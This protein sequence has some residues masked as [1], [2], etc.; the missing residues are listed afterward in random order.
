MPESSTSHPP[1]GGPAKTAFVLAG[2]GSFG[3]IQVGM[4]EVLVEHGI[5]PDFVI[6]SSVGALN[7]AYFASNPTADGVARLGQIWRGLR[8]ADIFPITLSGVVTFLRTREAFVNSE[9]LARLVDRHLPF[10]RIEDCRIPLHVVASD[11]LTGDAI[12]ISKGPVREAIIASAAI[13][14]AFRPVEVMGRYLLDG[15]VASNTPVRKAVELGARRLIILPTGFACALKEPPRGAI[16]VALHS[17][18]LLI[19]RQ[20]VAELESLGPE[21]ET[22]TAPPL[23]PLSGS[24]YDFTQADDLIRRGRASAEDWI[25]NGGLTSTAIPETM[26]PHTH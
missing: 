11:M 19:A 16:A 4:L 13:P 8:R 14:A 10:Q 9:G 17:I 1:A 21:I 26:R 12:A 18:T 15:A 25:R 23:C 5:K 3:A 6:G 7:A 22:H 20:L 2:G 24:A